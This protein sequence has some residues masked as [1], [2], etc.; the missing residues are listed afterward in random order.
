MAGGETY[1][2][3]SVVAK[4]E[5]NKVAT[6]MNDYSMDGV[7]TDRN[8]KKNITGLVGNRLPSLAEVIVSQAHS[9]WGRPVN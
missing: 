4:Y 8:A 2:N 9:I 6:R 3:R 7:I 5:G 1:V